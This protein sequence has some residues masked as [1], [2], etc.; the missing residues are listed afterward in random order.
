VQLNSSLFV[1][2][3][4]DLQNSAAMHNNSTNLAWHRWLARF[5]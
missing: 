3:I 2:L 1:Q 5:K 4:K